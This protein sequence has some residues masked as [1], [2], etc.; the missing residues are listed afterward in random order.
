MQDNLYRG[1]IANGND[2]NDSTC[3]HPGT[4]TCIQRRDSNHGK[5]GYERNPATRGT[6]TDNT[7]MIKKPRT[8][9]RKRPKHRPA[10]A[11][12]TEQVN[13]EHT[14]NKRMQVANITVANLASGEEV[15]DVEEENQDNACADP[16]PSSS[17]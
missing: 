8:K 1:P 4:R 14:Q 16:S 11:N 2:S 12:P 9:A 3:S 6:L 5:D 13:L 15:I 10:A 17:E 7:Q